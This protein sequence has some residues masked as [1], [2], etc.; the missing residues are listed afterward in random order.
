MFEENNGWPS[1]TPSEPV[2]DVESTENV[3]VQPVVEPESETNEPETV[4]PETES[5]SDSEPVKTKRRPRAR[6]PA[7]TT[8]SNPWTVDRV[9][10]VR[11]VL[12]LLDDPITKHVVAGLSNTDEQDVDKLA[13]NVLKGGLVEPVRLLVHAHDEQD[14][15]KRT[16]L[17]VGVLEKD[18]TLIRQAA[19][20]AI[21]L[22]E[23][24]N[25]LLKPAG[26]APM[27]LA[28]VLAQ[29]AGRLNVDPIR[30]LME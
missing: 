12:S 5:T 20:I 22:D 4:E 1:F 24:L 10:R 15:V 3:T 14:L 2:N 29:S 13:V 23:S 9:K 27:E 17:L 16:I 6:K 7:K 18:N 11:T 8:A 21:L 30:G 25:D 28:T 26:G 19:R